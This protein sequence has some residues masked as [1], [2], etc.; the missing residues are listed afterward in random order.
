[1]KPKQNKTPKETKKVTLKIKVGKERSLGTFT[2]VV[3]SQCYSA[4]IPKRSRQKGF[5]FSYESDKSFGSR[6]VSLF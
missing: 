5:F 2:L 6:R 4:W 1:M 3:L